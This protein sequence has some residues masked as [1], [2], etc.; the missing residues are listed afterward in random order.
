MPAQHAA[1]A[2]ASAII[3]II[4]ICVAAKT[5]TPELFVAIKITCQY[6]VAKT[7]ILGFVPAKTITPEL[8]VANKI[9]GQCGIVKTI[10]W[11]F[12]SAKTVTPK[13]AR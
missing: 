10:N 12:V 13:K 6:V 2:L 7:I 8:F 1:Q 3:T 11:I 5:I 9:T 4:R